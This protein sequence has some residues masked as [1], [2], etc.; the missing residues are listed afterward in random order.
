MADSERLNGVIKALAAGQPTFTAFATPDIPTAVAYSTSTGYDGIVFEMEHNPWDSLSLRDCLQFMLNRGQIAKSGSL[1]PA[2]TPMVRV[3]PNGNEMG[4]WQAKQA[5]DMGVYGVVWPHVSSVE[6]AYNAVAACRYP[7]MSDAPLYEPAGIRGDGPTQATRYWGLG[8]QE[9]YKKAD[10]WPLAP[11]GE[12]LVVLM[13]EDTKGIENLSDILKNVPGIGAVLIGEGDLSQELGYP[14]QYEHKVVLDAMA[15][16]VSTCKVSTKVWNS[17]DGAVS[18]NRPAR[19]RLTNN[20][21][22]ALSPSWP[23]N[24]VSSR[25]AGRGRGLVPHT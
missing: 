15:Q 19:H 9:Y 11:D 6:E 25:V 16:I 18:K 20:V 2:V 7:R 1:A 21:S 12:I 10:V 14:R 23:P 17:R 13:I 22:P 8:Q 3:P 4:Q 24:A 5:L